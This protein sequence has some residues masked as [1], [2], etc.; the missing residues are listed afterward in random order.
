[1]I[2]NKTKELIWHL[3]ESEQMSNTQISKEVGVSRGKVIEILKHPEYKNAQLIDKVN[4]INKEHN[5]TLIKI[6][7]DDNRLP[8]IVSKILSGIDDDT[9]I[10][11]LIDTGNIKPLMTVVGV[12][13]DKT[14]ASKRLKIEEGRLRALEK[15]VKLKEQELELRQS[16]PEAFAQ[17]IVIVNDIEDAKEHYKVKH[18]KYAT[19]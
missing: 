4:N 16:N 19:N 13:S 14:I 1:M 5:E 15:Q 10:K 11:G 6:L 7:R 18:D 12:L 17:D 8:S 9:V 2:S 3:K